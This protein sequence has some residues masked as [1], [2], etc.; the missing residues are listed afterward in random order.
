M[1]DVDLLFLMVIVICAMITAMAWWIGDVGRV[2][3]S[4]EERLDYLDQLATEA[5]EEEDEC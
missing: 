5:A 3:H 2:V 1:S 4:Q